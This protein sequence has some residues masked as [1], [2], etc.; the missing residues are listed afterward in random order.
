MIIFSVLIILSVFIILIIQ[1][2]PDYHLQLR[3]GLDNE[4]G[5]PL[6]LCLLVKLVLKHLNLGK[7]KMADIKNLKCKWKG[8]RYIFPGA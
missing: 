5:N 7:R 3:L 8:G 2:F 1:L 4:L 6:S